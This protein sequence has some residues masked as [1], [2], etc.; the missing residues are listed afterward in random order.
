MA[1]EWKLKPGQK[2]CS[3]C[4]K[5]NNNVTKIAPTDD[6]DID[7]I[8]GKNTEGDCDTFAREVSKELFQ[9]QVKLFGL[10]PLKSISSRD[11]LQ[12]G[13]RKLNQ[14][15]NASSGALLSAL[16]I[17]MNEI[18]VNNSF[19]ENNCCQKSEDLGKLVEMIKKNLWFHSK[20]K[21]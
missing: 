6:C 9:D 18:P 19:S 8:V 5:A 4:E 14:V 16:D 15:L 13:K 11:K 10:L 7:D 2:I 1:R 20:Q 21:K 3:S 17:S 12:Y